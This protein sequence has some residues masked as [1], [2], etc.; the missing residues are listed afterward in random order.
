[1]AVNRSRSM[2]TSIGGDAVSLVSLVFLVRWLGPVQRWW[3]REQVLAGVVRDTTGVP[4][5][6][7]RRIVAGA[8]DRLAAMTANV[9]RARRVRSWR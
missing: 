8:V 7:Q 2:A 9:E 5:M 3:W 6:V 4:P 1:M